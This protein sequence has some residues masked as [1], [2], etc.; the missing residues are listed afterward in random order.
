MINL[1]ISLGSSFFG[2]L[3]TLLLALSL[4]NIINKLNTSVNSLENTA[5]VLFGGGGIEKEYSS[6]KINRKDSLKCA[7]RLLVWGL[8]SCFL[9]TIGQVIIS[10]ITFCATK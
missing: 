7:T 5:G 9:G 1:F 3:G 2:V 10:I 4:N 8:V 6:N